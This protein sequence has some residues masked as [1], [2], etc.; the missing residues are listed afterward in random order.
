MSHRHPLNSNLLLAQ[1]VGLL[2]VTSSLATDVLAFAKFSV[3]PHNSDQPGVFA[4]ANT[5]G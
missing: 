2:R 4:D 1:N 3:T 5:P